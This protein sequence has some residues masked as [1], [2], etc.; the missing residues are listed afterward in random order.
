VLAPRMAVAPA[1]CPYHAAL[2]VD[3][4]TGQ[5]VGPLCRAGHV[6]EIRGFV[7]LPSRVAGWLD[8]QRRALPASPQWAE[9]CA[10]P[11]AER[12]PRIVSPGDGQVV[13]LVPG[14]AADQQE[15]PLY[16]D[17]A[18]PEV[19]WFLDGELV[20]T[21]SSR[22][23]VFVAPTPGAHEIVAVD[24]G[25]RKDRIAIEVRAAR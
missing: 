11:V 22:E 19:S 20:R 3:V 13:L 16:A 9:G 8:D 5:A 24:G 25:G 4:T 17:T 1:P 12:P 21:A 15:L 7:V 6:T 23:R 2:E 10:P 14:L 18:S